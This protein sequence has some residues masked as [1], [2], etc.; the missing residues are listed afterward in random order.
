MRV[1]IDAS[2]L[3]VRSAGVKNYLYHWILSL[4]HAAGADTIRTIP[5]MVHPGAL[6]HEAS[7]AGRWRTISGLARLARANYTALPLKDF[8]ARRADV[9]HASVLVRRP[10]SGPRLTATIYDAT[11]F[12]IP[13]MLPPENRLAEERFL[14]TARRAH[15]LIA[16]SESTK[17]DA[18]RVLGIPEEKIDVIYPGVAD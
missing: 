18:V 15:V 16:I 4:R 7:V 9:F 3:L 14:K 12:L 10:P 6:T 11:T 1:V 5:A 17:R 13:Q 8:A 2:P